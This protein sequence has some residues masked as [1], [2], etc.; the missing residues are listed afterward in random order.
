MITEKEGIFYL[1][2]KKTTYVFGVTKFKHLE[3]IYYGTKLTNEVEV[4]AVRYKQSAQTGTTVMYD[5]MLYNK[6]C[7]PILK[8]FDI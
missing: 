5:V 3:Q 6:N 1:N 2:T 4:G 8:D 7:H